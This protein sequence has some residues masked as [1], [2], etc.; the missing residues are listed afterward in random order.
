[1]ACDV[2]AGWSLLLKNLAAHAKAPKGPARV[3]KGAQRLLLFF[4]PTLSVPLI[5]Y[6]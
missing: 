3:I 4:I 5:D 1:M 2:L 6:Y